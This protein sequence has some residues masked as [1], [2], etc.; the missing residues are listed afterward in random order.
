MSQSTT[1]VQRWVF[2]LDI[3]SLTPPL[4]LAIL[5]SQSTYLAVLKKCPVFFKCR[6]TAESCPEEV[7][8]LCRDIRLS[9]SWLASLMYK[10]PAFI[11][12][13]CGKDNVALLVS[14]PSGLRDLSECVLVFDVH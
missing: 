5:S 8:R 4:K 3:D 1:S 13:L 6:L 7:A 10:F 12:A 2:Q 11:L 9:K 14:C